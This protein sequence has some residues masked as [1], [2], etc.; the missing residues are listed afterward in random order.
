MLKISL[1]DEDIQK[2]K[3]NINNG[4]I[5]LVLKERKTPSRTGA[6]HYLEVDQWKPKEQ[7]KEENMTYEDKK[8]KEIR[9]EVYIGDLPF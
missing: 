2:L 5:N 8:I 7:N 3:A 9:E 1:S 6:T 4:W